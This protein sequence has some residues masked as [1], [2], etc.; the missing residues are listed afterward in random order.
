METTPQTLLQIE[1]AIRKIA[2]KFPTE[3]EP[4]TLTDIHIRVTPETGE[5]VAFD[6]DDREITRC[7]IE[8]WIDEKDEDFYD[9]AASLLR[10]TLRERSEMIDS[11]SILK[12]FSFVLENEE[13]DVLY[14]LYVAD[15]D[16]VIIDADLMEG[17]NDELDDFFQDLMKK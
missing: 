16:T 10:K 1:R 12:P 2:E 6:D 17:L 14:E 13:L 8:A 5:L 4:T 3:V 9:H 7:I 11:M 15:G